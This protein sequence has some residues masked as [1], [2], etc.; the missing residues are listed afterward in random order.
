MSRLQIYDPRERALVRAADG[1]LAV[2]AAVARPFR[3]RARPAAP[4]RI[5]LLRL[6]RIG[7]LVMVLPA[8]RDV[9]ALAPAA[10]IDLVVGGWNAALAGAIPSV[11]SVETL[12]ARWLGRNGRG[13]GV[14]RLLAAARRWR[15]RRYDL[16]INFEPDIRSN[17]MLAASGA[18]WTAGWTSGGGGSLLDCALEYDGR[19]HTSS[20]ARRLVSSA[21]QRAAPDSPLDL[22]TLPDDVRRAAC[23]RLG[24][25][26]QAP[27]VGVH[28]SGGRPVKQWEPEKFAEVAQ[29]LAVERGATIVLT[30]STADRALVGGIKK[31]IP[32]RQVIDV[33]GEADLLLLA[34]LLER[35]DLLITG[36]TGP[37]HLAAA[38]STPIV[39][40]FGPS[41][42]RRYA[43]PGARI[44]RID[45]PCSPCNRIRLPP[46]RCKGHTPD[47]LAGITAD[48]VF[49]AAVSVLDRAS[50]RDAPGHA[51]A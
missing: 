44:V 17:L 34:A 14:G 19:A 39:A 51:T 36:D 23:V 29:R 8:I 45:L 2:A 12:D 28:A 5:L 37:M 46:A 40:V 42:P 48:A 21:F 13:T 7:D 4:A 6:E 43:P 50:L 11:S 49:D 30:G 9:R 38:V 33:S 27:L 3:R 15:T 47:C 35:L 10:A 31:T 24:P 18:G 1:A 16:A 41:D 25:G 32:A 22:L 26:L 20:N